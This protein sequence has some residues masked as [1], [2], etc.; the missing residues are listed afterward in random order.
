MFWTTIFGNF[1]I[2]N[3]KMDM[4]AASQP[5]SDAENNDGSFDEDTVELMNNM[6][7]GLGTVRSHQSVRKPCARGVT[8]PGSCGG[9]R[10]V[11]TVF[12][13]HH[14]HWKDTDE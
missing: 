14:E 3:D 13:S 1:T 12:H 10:D 7:V 2:P 5:F 8:F 9:A 11:L 4:M 6:M